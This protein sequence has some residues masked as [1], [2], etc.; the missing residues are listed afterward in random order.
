MQPKTKISGL[1][2]GATLTL[3][4]AL[5]A[6]AVALI[7]DEYRTNGIAIG[8]QA[9]SFNHFTAFEAIAKTAE[10]GG[11]VIEFF[12]GQKFSA[13][14]GDL[15]LDQNLPDDKIQ[16][17]KDQLAKYHVMA[18]NFGVVSLSANE[19]DDRKVFEFAKKLGLPAITT[20]FD[21]NGATQTMDVLEKLVKEYDIK[22]G[23]HDHPKQDN[24]PSYKNWDP[25]YILSLVK[26][27]DPRMGSCADT[28]HWVRSGIHPVDALRILQGRIM[29]CHLKD[30][31]E[32]SPG[33]HDV[34]YGEGKSDVPAI[35]DELKRQGF[36]GNISVE[37]E[38]HMEDSEAEISQCIGFIRGYSA[39]KTTSRTTF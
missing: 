22:I 25:N 19:A 17:L 35:L 8:C 18:V 10:A 11:K 12:P 2:V 26:N 29:S 20:E 13:D 9:W 4:G 28:G 39:P 23:I 36:Q 3:L 6:H 16:K 1:L 32:F 31:N 33:G 7:P 34:P 21:S 27:R 5:N 14:E 30:L 37:Y 15:K 24:N 38:Y